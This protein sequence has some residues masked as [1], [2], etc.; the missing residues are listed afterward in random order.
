MGEARMHIESP[1]I[2]HSYIKDN[3]VNDPF[4]FNTS[5]EQV[6]V[7]KQEVKAKFNEKWRKKKKQ[8]HWVDFRKIIPKPFPLLPSVFFLK[9]IKN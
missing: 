5:H 6:I 7:I 8:I 1:L 3:K 9:K 2:D 4:K